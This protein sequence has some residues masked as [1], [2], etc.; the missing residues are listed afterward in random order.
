[1]SVLQQSDSM[2]GKSA[3]SGPFGYAYGDMMM[4]GGEGCGTQD[5]GWDKDQPKHCPKMTDNEY[6]SEFSLYAIQGSPMIVGTDIRAMTPIMEELMFNKEV[7]SINQD[8][9]SPGGDV[10]H[11]PCTAEKTYLRKL[12]DGRFA[13]AVV[14]RRD[15]ETDVTVCVK[16]FGWEKDEAVVLD[17][18]TSVTYTTTGGKF[19]KRVGVHDTLLL[20]LSTPSNALVV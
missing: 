19:T 20:L 14:N 11:A 17:V 6:R 10:V 8:W 4:T 13:V 2:E 15:E 1:M 7:L 9:T 12:S 18:W 16:D 5:A 3:W